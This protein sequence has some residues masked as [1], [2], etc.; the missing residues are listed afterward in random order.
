MHFFRGCAG[1]SFLKDEHNQGTFTDERK[2]LFK[3]E[4]HGDIKKLSVV[5]K[6]LVK[7]AIKYQGLEH[8]KPSV[9]ACWPKDGV[10]EVSQWGVINF[11]PMQQENEQQRLIEVKDDGV[12]CCRMS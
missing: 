11:I 8:L 6:D 2:L 4:E 12:N 9:R 3:V 7:A 5:F 1:V 10:F